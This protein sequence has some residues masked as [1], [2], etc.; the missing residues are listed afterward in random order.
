MHLIAVVTG[1]LD[2][3]GGLTFGSGFV[4][5]AGP[6][7]GTTR[8]RTTGMP[9]VGGSLPAVALPSDIEE[10]GDEQVRALMMI[11]AN[12]ALAAPVGDRLCR[13]LEKLDLFISLDLY[14]N[15]TNR[16]ADY[17]L[18]CTTMWERE[19]APFL[20]MMG[21][22]LRPNMYAT[23]PVI[24]PVGDVKEEWQIIYELCDRLGA[25]EATKVK[26]REMIDGMIRNSQFGD[27]FGDNPN[28]LSYDKLLNEHP[29]GVALMDH[30]PV[31]VLEKFVANDNNLVHLAAPNFNSE[32]QR[33]FNDEFYAQ[34][35][36]PLRLHSMREVLTHNT[37]MHNAKSL[38]KTKRGHYARISAEDADRYGIDDD[39]EI[40]IRSPYGEVRI[41][42][43]ISK[44]ISPG[45]VALP[46]GWGHQGGWQIA[47]QRGGV[48]SNI[49]ASDRP[50]DSDRVS[51]ASVLNGIPTNISAT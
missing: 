25:S 7:M 36:F 47:N 21:M 31:G 2:S 1:N 12:P 5:S 8:S 46:H 35:E 28:G 14:V 4:D 49:L 44:K 43:R 29:N 51:G 24:E 27:K 23:A 18:P 22:A 38:A 13:A 37:W 19:D 33:L 26:P 10:P 34:P 39:S 3:A 30:K 6:K 50:S 15:E 45:N 11:G 48:N 32:M 40:W 9:S 20:V 42:A 41:T 17:I 16:Y